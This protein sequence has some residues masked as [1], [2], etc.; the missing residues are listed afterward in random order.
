M[1]KTCLFLCLWPALFSVTPLFSG[2]PLGFFRNHK[3]QT[4]G[5]DNTFFLKLEPGASI[6]LLEK[7]YG[8]TIRKQYEKA[9]FLVETNSTHLPEL[10]EKLNR[11]KGVEYARLNLY[12]KV[13]RR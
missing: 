5:Y 1:K 9:L 3:G 8:L 11:S 2:E 4:H 10:V 12:K 6:A 7:T 13:E